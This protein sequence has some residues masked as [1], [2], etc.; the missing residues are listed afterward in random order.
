[1]AHSSGGSSSSGGCH[2]G[3]GYSSSSGSHRS[4]SSHYYA[5]ASNR[6]V[7]YMNRR[8][9]YYYTSEPLNT[10]SKSGL[11]GFVV[12]MLIVFLLGGVVDLLGTDN[13]GFEH[14]GY[15]YVDHG[16][17]IKDS[18]GVITDSDA[19]V[20]QKALDT[21]LD[22]TGISVTFAT[23]DYNDFIKSNKTLPDITCDKY[24]STFNDECH[25]LIVFAGSK[26]DPST[27]AFEGVQGDDTDFII[28][29]DRAD[30]FNA[31]VTKELNNGTSPAIAFADVINDCAHKW[32]KD[33][34]PLEDP[35]A[36]ASLI[37]VFIIES[38]IIAVVVLQYKKSK[39][40]YDNAKECPTV[41]EVTEVA[42]EY[43]GGVYVPGTVTS[44]PY[45][46]ATI[47]P[48]SS[49]VKS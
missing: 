25:W 13:P 18:A 44:C 9:H 23:L 10:P 27:W 33:Y 15:R 7:Y 36:I 17:I 19:E 1:M 38:V 47:P 29:Q 30:R 3:S 34:T 32:N 28:T 16:A 5:D 12:F 37:A 45:C 22:N 20:L 26:E 4:Y 42:C 41:K 35:N 49:I 40:L 8:P 39:K 43:C 48:L 31:A 2:S 11:I 6:Y 46:G 14:I 24:V 21:F